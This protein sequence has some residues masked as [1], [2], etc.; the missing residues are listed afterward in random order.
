MSAACPSFPA[1]RGRLEGALDRYFS[2]Q[3][4]GCGR[5][6]AI[7]LVGHDHRNGLCRWQVRDRPVPSGDC[8]VIAWR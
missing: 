4:L 8:E 3:D 7:S 1:V 5:L 2:S 6:S